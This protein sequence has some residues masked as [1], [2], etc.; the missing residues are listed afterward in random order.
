MNHMVRLLSR[1]TEQEF[2]MMIA[3]GEAFGKLACKG[4]LASCSR[5]RLDAFI[6]ALAE[7]E[8][9]GLFETER[10]AFD[11]ACKLLSLK[12]ERMPSAQRKNR[13]RTGRCQ[14]TTQV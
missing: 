13:H 11:L 6:A 14:T 4:T 9:R 1:L 12:D 3:V 7:A 8:R 10:A 5:D 2:E